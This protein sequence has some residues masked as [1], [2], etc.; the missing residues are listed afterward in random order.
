MV[1]SLGNTVPG[2]EFQF[3]RSPHG[4]K[5]EREKKNAWK[6]LVQG[7]KMPL[8]KNPRNVP[9]VVFSRCFIETLSYTFT[10]RFSFFPFPV[11]P[12]DGVL[13]L[14]NLFDVDVFSC[15]ELRVRFFC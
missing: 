6:T 8:K 11:P 3:R 15:C 10:G 4:G 14:L 2:T 13:N 5:S 12:V 9:H 1:L 7:R